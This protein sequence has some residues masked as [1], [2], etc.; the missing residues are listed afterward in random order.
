MAYAINKVEKKA[1]GNAITKKIGGRQKLL[2]DHLFAICSP[3]MEDCCPKGCCC[4]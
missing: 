2:P 1:Y 3:P 4:C